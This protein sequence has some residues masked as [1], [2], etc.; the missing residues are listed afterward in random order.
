M[1]KKSSSLLNGKTIFLSPKCPSLF[2]LFFTPILKFE[3]LLVVVGPLISQTQTQ[4]NPHHF[5]KSQTEKLLRLQKLLPGPAREKSPSLFHC[6]FINKSQIKCRVVTLLI[7]H[8][9]CPS[10]VTLF[11]AYLLVVVGPL[12][13]QTQTQPNPHHFLKSQTEKLLR[14]QKLKPGP[15]REKVHPC[16]IAFL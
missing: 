4:P 7:S 11:H 2:H 15:A 5:L 1:Q 10:M 16:F 13:S 9:L 8:P 6:I 14:L 3:H 12:I